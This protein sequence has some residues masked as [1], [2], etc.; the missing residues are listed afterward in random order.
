MP[1][2]T[3]SDAKLRSLQAPLKGQ[4]EYR[5][6]SFKAGSFACRVSQRG[7][8]DLSSQTPQPPLHDRPVPYPFSQRG[9]HGS[10][11]APSRIH[12]RESTPPIYQLCQGRRA[13][14]RRKREEPPK[15]T[16]DAYKGLLNR[17]NF[18]GPIAD[19]AHQ[20]VRR[21]LARITT[22]GAYNHHLVALKV[23]FN[24]AV[25]CRYL[26]ENP[27]LGFSRHARARK[28]RILTDDELLSVWRAAEK[29][30]QL[31]QVHI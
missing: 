17:L 19:I 31:V 11:E 25:K 10:S 20:E 26:S 14:C 28:K 1:I 9:P 12:S 16:A 15:S 4:I 22:P 24:W 18:T 30:N 13:L 29:D 5:D 7:V 27:T 6:A 2:V 23:F 3:L 8:K 21:K